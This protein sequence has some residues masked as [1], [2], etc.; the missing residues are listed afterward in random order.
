MAEEDKQCRICL[1]GD[2]PENLISP[3]LCSGGS[4]YIHRTCLQ[5][6]RERH[7]NE[8]YYRCNEC[9]FAYQ[10]RRVWWGSV[11]ASPWTQGALTIG[12]LTGYV[13]LSGQASARIT[14]VLWSYFH[15]K[16][17]ANPHRLQVLFHGLFWTAVPGIYFFIRDLLAVPIEPRIPRNISFSVPNI[18]YF[19]TTVH[20][21]HH[22]RKNSDSSSDESKSPR[23]KKKVVEYEAPNIGAWIVV[24]MGAARCGYSLYQVVKR[25]AMRICTRAQALIENIN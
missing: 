8:S 12:L 23:N 10:Y 11:L 5:E 24:I 6:W 3:C 19:P 7:V 1:S 20:H 16:D 9:R 17:N 2:E 14:N 21:Y 13:Y 15:H 25:G 22:E 4:R 18:P